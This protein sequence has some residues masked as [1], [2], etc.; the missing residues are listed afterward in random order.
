[1]GLGSIKSTDIDLP[2]SCDSVSLGVPE[3]E[4]KEFLCELT[5]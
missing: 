1:M 4:N 3:E 5:K 2:S